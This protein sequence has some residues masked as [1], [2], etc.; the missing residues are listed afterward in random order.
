MR[1]IWSNGSGTIANASEEWRIADAPQLPFKCDGIFFDEFSEHFWKFI[2]GGRKVLDK[3]EREAVKEYIVKQVK[4]VHVPSPEGIALANQNAADLAAFAASKAEPVIQY[5]VS[6]T[7][8]E[9]DAYVKANISSLAQAKAMLGKFSMALC[10][11]SKAS[12]R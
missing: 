9:C 10:V 5:L 7:P 2:N 6:H 8:A 12:L 1:L 3:S 4:P 11:L